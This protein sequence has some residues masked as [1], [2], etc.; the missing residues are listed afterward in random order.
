MSVNCIIRRGHSR[1]DPNRHHGAKTESYRYYF[2]CSHTVL[3]RMQYANNTFSLQHYADD[4][5]TPK[6]GQ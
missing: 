6:R 2:L 1:D 3:L 5:S 4:E